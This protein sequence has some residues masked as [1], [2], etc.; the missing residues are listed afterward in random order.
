MAR[1]EFTGKDNHGKPKS[2]YLAKIAAMTDDALFTETERKIWLSAYAG[3]N[4]RSDYHWHTDAVYDEWLARGKLSEYD[5]AY[6][7]A[8]STMN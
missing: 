7:A 1:R 4:P 8:R 2:E 6:E 5:R 3:N